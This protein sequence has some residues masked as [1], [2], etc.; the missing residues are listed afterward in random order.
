[1]V[2]SWY[3]SVKRTT[4]KKADDLIILSNQ[5]K[6]RNVMNHEET[7]YKIVVQSMIHESLN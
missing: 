6:T 3:P 1:M 2:W 5:G 7:V 4:G